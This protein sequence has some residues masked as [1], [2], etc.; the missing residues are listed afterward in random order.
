VQI[1]LYQ[2][3]VLWMGVIALLFSIAGITA[4]IVARDEKCLYCLPSPHGREKNATVA[5]E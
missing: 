3:V 1:F 5:L 4:Q 2:I